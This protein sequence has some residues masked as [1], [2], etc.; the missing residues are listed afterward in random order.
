MAKSI[1]VSTEINAPIERVWHEVSNIKNHPTWM[2]YARNM[3][4]K[5]KKIKKNNRNIK[6]AHLIFSLLVVT[7]SSGT[8]V[9][10]E[11]IVTTS[12]ITTIHLDYKK[13]L[14]GN[15]Q[16]FVL[17]WNRLVSQVSKNEETIFFFSI[18]PNNLIWADWKRDTLVYQ[19][20]NEENTLTGFTL[21]LN[22]NPESEIV[23]GIEFFSP[24][25]QNSIVAEQTKFFL[26]LL[27]AIS[28]PDLNKEGRETVLSNLGLYENVEKPELMSGSVTKNNITYQ[29]E[30]LV[31]SN[32]LIGLTLFIVDNT[33]S[34]PG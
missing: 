8:L 27:I 14:G 34:T 30:P 15:P 28:D 1:K 16:N 31:D 26:L 6:V 33:S 19:F 23:Y 21:N 3:D 9:G 10:E 2:K 7:C 24:A 25:S 11:P 13:G 18:N 20:G 17:N 22:L 5:Y 4:K 29:L 12:T 32:L